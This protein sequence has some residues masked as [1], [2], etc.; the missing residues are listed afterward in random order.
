VNERD[1]IPGETARSQLAE[2]VAYLKD[3]GVT[4]L[5][6]IEK[7]GQQTQ[8][9][10]HVGEAAERL[11]KIRADL[12]ECTRC[13]LHEGRTKLVFGVGDPS[14]QLMFI[15]EGPGAN[16]DLQGEPFVGRAG[17]KLDEMIKAIGL[18]R[19]SVYIAN[20]VKCRP[21]ENR[22]PAADE[23][24]ICSPVLDAQIEAIQPKVIVTLG[25][26]S[27]K[28]LLGTKVGITRLRGQWHSYRDIPVMP[29]FHPA[30]LLRNYTRETRMMVWED[31]KAA[32][33]RME[34]S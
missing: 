33:A 25:G 12:G 32:R 14:A 20:I 30:Y 15:G 17:K 31:L 34:E 3:I 11:Q 27:T 7:T 28:T 5:S 18:S 9:A 24:A 21:P 10:Q 6:K 26:P 16:E 23:I 2:W 29:T 22:D 13:R 1:A 19:E 4:D 8:D